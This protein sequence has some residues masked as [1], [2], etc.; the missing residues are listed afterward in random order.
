MEFYGEVLSTEG[1]YEFDDYECSDGT[2]HN[3]KKLPLRCRGPG[4]DGVTD[5]KEI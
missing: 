1:R 2:E 3:K 5:W 4:K